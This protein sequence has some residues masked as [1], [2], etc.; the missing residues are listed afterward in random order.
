MIREDCV[1]RGRGIIHAGNTQRCG[2]HRGVR[3]QIAAPHTATD[4]VLGYGVP[5]KCIQCTLGQLNRYATERVRHGE[6]RCHVSIED[7][8]S[9]HLVSEV[10][11][12]LENFVR[13]LSH[14]TTAFSS[15]V[16]TAP[17]KPTIGSL[18]TDAIGVLQLVVTT[19]LCTRSTRLILLPFELVAIERHPCVVGWCPPR[20]RGPRR[21][22]ES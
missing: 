5:N 3:A 11:P 1:S 21:R 10:C 19:N 16:S 14:K 2:V 4:T 17:E 18:H 22:V 9:N 7:R 15:K 20:W 6:P 12:A 8:E 13:I